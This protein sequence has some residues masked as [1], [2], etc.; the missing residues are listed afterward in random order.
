MEEL[1]ARKLPTVEQVE[2]IMREWGQ[3]SL[4]AFARRFDL[5]VAVVEATVGYLR[6]MQR[7]DDPA[8]LPAMVCYRDDRLESIVRCAGARHGYL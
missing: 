4:E 2:I 5:E 8:S 3:C 1:A 6:Q 7:L